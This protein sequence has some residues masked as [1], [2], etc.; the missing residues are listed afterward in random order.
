VHSS[1]NTGSQEFYLKT[2]QNKRGHSSLKKVWGVF[3]KP[4]S[5]FIRKNDLVYGTHGIFLDEKEEG[6]P[7]LS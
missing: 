7:E 6:P 2:K 1:K 3:S 5:Y 4:S